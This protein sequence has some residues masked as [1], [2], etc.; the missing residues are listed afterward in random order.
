M[1]MKLTHMPEEVPAKERENQCIN[2]H[3]PIHANI[4]LNTAKNTKNSA[5]R[6]LQV[7]IQFQL[8]FQQ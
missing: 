5:L 1:I 6:R 7:K 3:D 8:V 4:E 2:G